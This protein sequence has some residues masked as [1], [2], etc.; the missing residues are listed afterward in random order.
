MSGQ[1]LALALLNWIGRWILTPLAR[2]ICAVLLVGLLPLLALAWMVTP[3]DEEPEQPF[4]DF[5]ADVFK[6]LRRGDR[7]A[8]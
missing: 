7:W 1:V 8:K 4:G 3:G 2:L 6:S 5:V